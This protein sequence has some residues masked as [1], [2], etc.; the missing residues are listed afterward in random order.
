MP[1]LWPQVGW[2]QRHL[3]VT[4]EH[5]EM[6]HCWDSGCTCS[7]QLALLSSSDPS[8][9]SYIYP[10]ACARWAVYCKQRE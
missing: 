10:G 4:L 5:N 9:C 2:E 7:Q 6:Q 8:T 1:L 3:R